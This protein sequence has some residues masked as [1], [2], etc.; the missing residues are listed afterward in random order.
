[1]HH[2][3][4]FDEGKDVDTMIWKSYVFNDLTFRNPITGLALSYDVFVQQY[5]V[6][7]ERPYLFFFSK[8][9]PVKYYYSVKNIEINQLKSNDLKRTYARLNFRIYPIITKAKIRSELFTD[10]LAIFGSYWCMFTLLGRMFAQTWGG[11]FYKA[12]LLNTVFK[13]QEDDPD[14]KPDWPPFEPHPSETKINRYIEDQLEW[15]KMKE[16]GF[17]M[18]AP[19]IEMQKKTEEVINLNINKKCDPV[20]K[21]IVES[22]DTKILREDLRPKKDPA[23]GDENLIMNSLES[24]SHSQEDLQKKIPGNQLNFN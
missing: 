6:T 10:T 21:D 5:S 4:E 11:Y 8:E 9:D 19:V 20:P 2:K 14:Y 16:M 3:I 13:Y 22:V 1:M 18:D 12:D 23:S 17:Q 24:C 7:I 15:N